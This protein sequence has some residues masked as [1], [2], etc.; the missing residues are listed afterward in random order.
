MIR[1]HIWLDKAYEE[2]QNLRHYS[3]LQLRLPALLTWSLGIV[4]FISDNNILLSYKVT[5]TI[6]QNTKDNIAANTR[7]T[8]LHVLNDQE[9]ICMGGGDGREGIW[10]V[11][12][13]CHII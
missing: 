11:Y 12:T 13:F 4:G 2:L 5:R 10:K 9:W 1:G 3:R 6:K 8:S 7:K